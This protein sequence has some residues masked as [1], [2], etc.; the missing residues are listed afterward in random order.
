MERTPPSN[1]NSQS[2][3]GYCHHLIVVAGGRTG[4][5]GALFTI[6]ILD[7]TTLQ[8]SSA[9]S[10]PEPLWYPHMSLC[11]EHLYISEH[12]KIFSCSVE[13]LFKWCKPAS[14]N[15]SD[16]IYRSV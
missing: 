9:S 8:W 16:G 5:H 15:S 10:S 1:A 12:S 6:E 7:T 11:G 13:R 3:A 4:L 2:Q 14:T